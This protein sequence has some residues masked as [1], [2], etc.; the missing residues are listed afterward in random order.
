MKRLHS[1]L[2]VLTMLVAVF[3][4]CGSSGDNSSP[5]AEPSASTAESSPSASESATGGEGGAAPEGSPSGK[6]TVQTWQYGI[7]TFA[8]E[9]DTQM[10]VMKFE[11]YFES[12][13]PDIDAE[14]THVQY[15]EHLNRL[16]VDFASGMG[17]DV[18]GLQTGA[19]LVEF[20]SYLVDMD[21]YAVRDLGAGY[22]D[23]IF[24]G[25]ALDSVSVP[26]VGLVGFP[27]FLSYAGMMFYSN[28]FLEAAGVTA[29][30]T[31]YDELKSAAQKLRDSG[32][33]P[34][35]TGAKD[36]W[37]NL[38]MYMVIAADFSRDKLYS[39][40]EGE[41]AWTDPD[42]VSALEKFQQLFTDGIY[43]DGALG[44]N[45]Y[46]E[47]VSLWNETGVG[48][49][50]GG[51]HTNG[52]WEMSAFSSTQ[53]TYETYISYNRG[54][55]RFPDMNGDGIPCPMTTAPDAIFCLTSVSQNPEAGWAFIRFMINEEGMQATADSMMGFPANKNFQPQIE[56]SPELQEVFTH[57][58]EMA[59]DNGVA[60]YREIPYSDLK[61]VLSDQLQLLGASGTTPQE[62][63]EAIEAASQAQAR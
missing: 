25:G 32:A 30:P 19:P 27:T 20:K 23:E 40:I 7:G 8:G 42:L 35:I 39:A 12:F 11:E 6:L 16:K 45:M 33:L 2:L 48:T 14:F 57:I 52:S 21:P 38:D 4:G 9:T 47:A 18:I 37:I 53:P 50:K 41:T 46:N 28:Q 55:E 13:Y 63:A 60:G 36:A 44:V 31:N 10:Q 34:M 61:Q 24:V 26:E 62:A 22:K 54:V 51:L 56:L 49:C 5:A 58:Q 29:P 17:P 1:I 15:T 43:Q 59:A 3:A